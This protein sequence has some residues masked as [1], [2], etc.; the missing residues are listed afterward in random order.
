MSGFPVHPDYLKTFEQI[1][2]HR[3]KRGAL[4]RPLRPPSRPSFRTGSAQLTSRCSSAT[5]A[6]GT[7]SKQL[8]LRA[9]PN[10]KKVLRVEVLDRTCSR[11]FTRPAYKA[12]G[13]GVI[14]WP[15][16]DLTTGG[17]IHVPIGPTAAELRDALCLFQPGVEDMP[18]ATRPR[19]CCR[20]CRP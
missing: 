9:D 20:W 4:A 12:R 17:D 11:V 8:G 3:E 14:G 10:I 6:S 7:P 1:H 19:I 16:T 5:R 15:S 18:R 13:A 2:L